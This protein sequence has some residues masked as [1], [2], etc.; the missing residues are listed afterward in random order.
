MPRFSSNLRVFDGVAA[1]T[2]AEIGQPAAGAASAVTAGSVVTIGNFDGVHLGHQELIRRACEKAAEFAVPCVVLTFEPHPLAVLRPE[3]KV[4]RL[5]DSD[6][7]RNQMAKLGVDGLIV[8]SFSRE[9]SQLSP[10]SFLSDIIIRPL[11]PRQVVVGYDFSFGA[12]RAGSIELLQAKARE[13][14]FAVEVLPPVSVHLPGDASGTMTTV[15]STRIRA[16]LSL[17][18]VGQAKSLL[19][20]PYMLRGT[21]TKGAGRGRTIGIPTANIEPT[22]E[23]I[24]KHGVYAAMA[25]VR[26]RSEKALVNIGR[27]PTFL[28]TETVHVEAHLPEYQSERE[29]DLYGE[30]L[31][32]NFEFRLRDEMKFASRDE[33]VAQ[34][35]RDIER[36]KQGLK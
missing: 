22:V 23:P 12:D 30:R 16:A 21:V 4:R 26:G 1:Y 5:F 11:R 6:D 7:R 33:L 19:G 27:N 15:S 31:E 28:D 3:L 8:Q 14:G 10:E 32:L 36:G 24:L 34:I 29:G 20:R 35:R 2:A 25:T 13:Q 17:G 9:F 18:E